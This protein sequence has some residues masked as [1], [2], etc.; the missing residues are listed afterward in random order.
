[1]RENEQEQKKIDGMRQMLDFFEQHPEIKLPYFYGPDVY[2]DKPADL[3]PVIEACGKL[4]KHFVGSSFYLR[5]T[6]DG[7]IHIDFNVARENICEKKVTGVRHVPAS[8]YTTEAH[9][10]EIVEWSCP[11]SLLKKLK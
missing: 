6:F 4:E 7:G 11:D 9:D 5:K 3:F 10:E 2:F 1:M 8:T